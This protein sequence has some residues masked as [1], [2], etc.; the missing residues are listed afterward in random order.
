MKAFLAVPVLAVLWSTSGS[1]RAEAAASPAFDYQRAQK[2]LQQKKPNEKQLTGLLNQVKAL[3]SDPPKL[4]RAAAENNVSLDYEISGKAQVELRKFVEFGGQVSN[5]GGSLSIGDNLIRWKAS[6][7]PNDRTLGS[8]V[9]LFAAVLP[10]GTLVKQVYSVEF[11]Y[12]D[13]RKYLEA[14]GLDARNLPGAQTALRMMNAVLGRYADE[15][16]AGKTAPPGVVEAVT[17]ELKGLLPQIFVSAQQYEKVTVGQGI[18]VEDPTG[19]VSVSHMALERVGPG[20]TVGEGV[21]YSETS[22]AG[23]LSAGV[24]GKAKAGVELALKVS[25][26]PEKA[27]DPAK[28]EVVALL[29]QGLVGEV[30]K[31]GIEQFAPVLAPE[32]IRQALEL[33]DKQGKGD[34]EDPNRVVAVDDPK[35]GGV[36][37]Y[38]DPGMLA[39]D[40]PPAD[41]ARVLGRLLDQRQQGH[42]NFIVSSQAG[43]W[44][45]QAVSLKDLLADRN[46]ETLGPLTRAR[47]FV[48]AADGDFL[49]LG[50]V[51]PGESPLDLDLLAVALRAVWQGNQFP[52]VSLDPDPLDMGGKQNV[53]VGGVP[54]DLRDTEFVRLMLEADYAMKR[55][56]LGEDLLS[57]PGYRNSC[58]LARA[59]PPR[60]ELTSRLWLVPMPSRTADVWEWT[61]DNGT[62]VLFDSHVQVLTETMK[63]VQ[64]YLVGAGEAD[65]LSQAEAEGFTAHYAEIAAQRDAFRKL[66][67][68]FEVTKLCALL[69]DRKV[70]HPLLDR[71]AARPIRHVEIPDHYTGIGPKQ[72]EGTRVVVSGGANSRVRLSKSAYAKTETLAGLLS[73]AGGQELA[74]AYPTTVA[75]STADALNAQAEIVFNRGVG[76]FSK[77]DYL[78]AEGLLTEALQRDP[79][80][81]G[82]RLYRGLSRFVRDEHKAALTDLNVAVRTVPEL[83]ALRGLLRV[84]LGDKQGALQ[85]AAAAG[86]AF[87][88]NEAV[89]TW[90]S[91]TYL[92]TF[93]LAKAEAATERL[94]SLN[95]LDPDAA[96][97]WTMLELLYKLGP[98]R[99]RQR[100]DQ[101]RRVP[102]MIY[103]TYSEGVTGIQRFAL[104]ESIDKLKRCLALIDAAGADPAV[105]ALHLRERAELALLMALSFQSKLDQKLGAAEGERS[106]EAAR[107][108]ADALVKRHPDWPTA[109]LLQGMFLA[110]ADP[111]RPLS[112]FDK[113][114]K[115]KGNAD[116]LLEDLSA[117]LGTGRTLAW[118]GISLFYQANE[119]GRSNPEL[120]DLLDRIL[121]V[122]GKGPE[123]PLLKALRDTYRLPAAFEKKL[124]A[125]LLSFGDQLPAEVRQAL[126]Q[127]VSGKAFFDLLE[128]VM[129]DAKVDENDPRVKQFA[130]D[131]AADQ[132]TMLVPLRT[133]VQALSERIPADPVTVWSVGVVSLIYLSMEFE[134]GDASL[135]TDLALKCLRQT[136]VDDLPQATWMQIGVLR[137]ALMGMLGERFERQFRDDPRWGQLKEQLGGGEVDVKQ[138]REAL[139]SAKADIRQAAL[140]GGSPFVAAFLGFG[141]SGNNAALVERELHGVATEAVPRIQD[142]AR[143]DREQRELAEWTA[144]L[145]P[146]PKE[147]AGLLDDLIGSVTRPADLYCLNF[148][149]TVFTTGSQMVAQEDPAAAADIARA[150]RQIQAKIRGLQLKRKGHDWGKWAKGA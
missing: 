125:T 7:N 131:F 77:G 129:P 73:L 40:V 99:A 121:P 69:K 14:M 74:V 21:Q 70:S 146:A 37:L 11:Q 36:H 149:T 126:K 140:R 9:E 110:D 143:R 45:L 76:A 84:Y 122:M 38:Y 35:A 85:D 15:V 87:S 150:V 47:G 141:L 2:V 4:A 18:S 104:A 12:G 29:A 19:H 133:A 54:D 145:N 25:T 48:Q 97:T 63:R 112:I 55:I 10:N 6:A 81:T 24:G 79:E 135:A 138:V 22:F 119:Q 8:T 96:G 111:A 16:P 58:E 3:V 68:V 103:D 31:R 49:L 94:L 88:D 27:P 137:T 17:T 71:L 89:L 33:L 144:Q 61:R 60:G 128:R 72:V 59:T 1:A 105:G 83:Q 66:N 147:R 67:T 62:A 90:N 20:Q 91:A 57:V 28:A 65:P 123:V 93:D 86:K 132:T 80:L 109:Y 102:L 41:V 100:V 148:L 32:R 120:A 114:L 50:E 142:P 130:K 136:D 115:Y 34:G 53:R 56:T 116:P 43:E 13:N 46:A 42:G 127:G 108:V 82:A 113:A 44:R 39:T 52:F 107:A 5:T 101:L 78:T 23:G 98:K 139:E 26:D 95:P 30:A 92:Y 106:T 117:Y 134:R 51:E 118:F 75:L 124:K 64:D